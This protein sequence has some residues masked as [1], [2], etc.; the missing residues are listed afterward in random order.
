MRSRATDDAN[1]SLGLV[2]SMIT[3]YV[4]VLTRASEERDVQSFL[5]AWTFGQAGLVP[6]NSFLPGVQ[7]NIDRSWSDDVAAIRQAR[8]ARTASSFGTGDEEARV[9]QAL[10]DLLTRS[11]Y[12]PSFPGTTEKYA[13]LVVDGPDD[14]RNIEPQQVIDAARAQDVRIFI[15]HYDAAVTVSTNE[16]LFLIP[17]STT[18]VAAQD[19]QCT[20]DADCENFEQC[21]PVTTFADRPNSEVTFPRDK[22]YVGDNPTAA[23][24]TF[25]AIRRDGNGRIGPIDDYA[26]IACATGGGYLYLDSL[27]Q[28]RNQADWLPTVVDGLWEQPVNVTGFGGG[29]LTDEQPYLLD[30]SVTFSVSGG[31]QS[32]VFGS[33]NAPRPVLFDQ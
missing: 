23:R 2:D 31:T 1:R 5:G 14:F 24:Q 19:T 8:T 17:D 13:I 25:C 22:I 12:F 9:F 27:D 20:S 26:E 33:N 21:R 29:S 16:G 32:L 28:A 30:T 10:L 3:R 11:E 18:Y 15:V 7:A 4:S 6:G